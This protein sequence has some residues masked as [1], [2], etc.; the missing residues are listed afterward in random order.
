MYPS[1]YGT[2]RVDLLTAK[3]LVNSIV[4]TPGSRFIT[5][6]INDVYLNTS[7]D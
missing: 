3:L 1:D 6:D 2:T 7:I 4:S 5:I